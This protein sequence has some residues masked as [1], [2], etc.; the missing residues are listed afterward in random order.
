[1]YAELAL[2]YK[3]RVCHTATACDMSRMLEHNLVFISLCLVRFVKNGILNR[4]F[5]QE[6]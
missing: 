4:I 2:F 1:M 5:I 6:T 3:R